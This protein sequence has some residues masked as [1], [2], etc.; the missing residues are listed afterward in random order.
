MNTYILKPHKLNTYIL[1]SHKLCTCRLPQIY[2]NISILDGVKHDQ[3]TSNMLPIGQRMDAIIYSM[4]S[5][6]YSISL[7]L[8][9]AIC[10]YWL[11]YTFPYH[12]IISR[13]II[14]GNLCNFY[15][16]P[17][18]DISY[19]TIIHSLNWTS[20]VNPAIFKDNN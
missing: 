15:Q 17:L 16:F 7:I 3:T 1:N 6:L 12:R 8:F 5:R 4:V 10:S 20:E 13:I 14:S 19:K 2:C 18:S 11:P 9:L